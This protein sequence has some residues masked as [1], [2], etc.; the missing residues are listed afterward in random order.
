MK[1][2]T[3]TSIELLLPKKIKCRDYNDFAFLENDLRGMGLDVVVEEVGFEAPDYIGLVHTNTK[4]HRQL[5][6]QLVK[7][8]AD[9]GA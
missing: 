1:I 9:D 4:E 6:K 5:V 7:F 2:N 8:Y 3:D